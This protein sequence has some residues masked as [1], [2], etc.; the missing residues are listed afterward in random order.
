MTQIDH[1]LSHTFPKRIRKAVRREGADRLLLYNLLAFAGSVSVTRLFL[2]MTGYPQ[3][4][5]NELHIAHVLWG[6]LLLYIATLVPILYANRWAL[7]FSSIVSGI[8]IGL[9]IDE[10]GK[11]ITQANDYFYPPA[12]PIIY[13]LFLV[14]VF[15]YNRIRKH[16]VRDLRTELYR[17]LDGLEEVLDH[18]LS[19]KEKKKLTEQLNIVTGQSASPDVIRLANALKEFAESESLILVPEPP[20]FW[21]RAMQKLQEIE[22]RLIG[23]NRFRVLL[24]GGI[25]A[26]AMWSLNYPLMTLYQIYQSREFE[27]VLIQLIQ[28]RLVRSPLTLGWFEVRLVLEL[29][30]GLL[31]LVAAVFIYMR[32]NRQALPLANFGLLLSL[33]TVDLLRFYFDQFSTIVV[34][35]IQLGLLLML[36][37]YRSRYT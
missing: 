11:F 12:A 25:L 36:N 20:T 1:P 8:G 15:L 19:E 33:T 21:D 30:V 10:V 32:K 7:T 28:N 5:I 27:K 9:F 18:D 3:L 24:S 35:I 29:I 4:S 2:Q 37:Y 13:S 14:T 26:M 16:E 6:G 22:R 31:L 17:V 23:S 34:A